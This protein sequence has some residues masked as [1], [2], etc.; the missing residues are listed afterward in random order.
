MNLRRWFLCCSAALIGAACPAWAQQQGTA[1]Q[2]SGPVERRAVEAA[3]WGIPIVN[4]EAMRE[5]YF[6]DAGAQYNDIVYWSKNPDAKMQLLTPNTTSHYAYANF[7]TRGGPVVFELPP[8]EGVGMYHNLADAWQVP[9]VD[10]GPNG[11][12]RGKGGK[13]LLLPPGHKGDAPAGYTPIRMPTYNGYFLLRSNP[14]SQAARDV[15]Q[16][17]DWIRKVRLYPLADADAPRAQRYIDVSGK[18]IDG[19]VRMDQSYFTRLARILAEEPVRPIDLPMMGM[20]RTLGITHDRP[21]APDA[22]LTATLDLAA[23]QAHREIVASRTDQRQPWWPGSKWTIAKNLMEAAKGG[24]TFEVDDSLLID[25][26]AYTFYIA[27]A[28]SAKLG[29]ATFYLTQYDEADGTPLSGDHDY[30]LRVPADVPAEQFWAATVYDM[31]SA[32]FLRE[33]PVVGLDSNDRRMKRNA[34]GSVDIYFGATPPR[35]AEANWIYVRPGGTWFAA[36][37][38]YGPTP[39]LFDKSWAMPN[40]ER[41]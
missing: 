5:A 21:F 29:G 17:N 2:I 32:S 3:I 36:F 27:F 12:D 34:D 22:A 25:Q 15:A 40:I 1:T 30:V 19:V 7:N 31:D 4:F 9:V 16:A 28:L 14:K 39:R 18:L 38:F 37:R 26:R 35:G 33:A 24:F 6:R 23:R 8:F 11:L 41:R 10:F 13:F 20:L